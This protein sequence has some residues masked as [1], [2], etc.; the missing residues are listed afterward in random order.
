MLKHSSLHNRYGILS[1]NTLLPLSLTILATCSTHPLATD[2]TSTTAARLIFSIRP[3]IVVLWPYLVQRVTD[4]YRNTDMASS[5]SAFQSSM[6][7]Q[8]QSAF[9][10]L[11]AELR[12]R[13][14]EMAFECE[15]G[16][17]DLAT[18]FR[19]GGTPLELGSAAP[20]S[21]ALMRSC[22]TTCRES[23]GIFMSACEA[24]WNKDFVV[25]LS[26]R[27]FS[28]SG[29]Y[30]KHIPDSYLVRVSRIVLL[31]TYLGT[32]MRVLR[33]WSD[34][35]W[36]A[37]ISAGKSYGVDES[38]LIDV[39]RGIVLEQEPQSFSKTPFDGFTFILEL[40]K[41]EQYRWGLES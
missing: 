24:Y 7:E 22:Q 33:T 6:L 34:G 31:C 30:I 17:I 12:N 20:P 13:I 35:A 2:C 26:G 18:T 37:E 8:K 36:E 27:L 9:F 10:K 29:A 19:P 41:Q 32:E 28:S 11:P 5:A 21:S 14:Y 38:A 4:N 1:A 23:R 16:T 3:D 15:L 40:L 25:D 39:F